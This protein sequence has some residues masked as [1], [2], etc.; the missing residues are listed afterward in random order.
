MD[1]DVPNGFVV[2][3]PVPNGFVPKPEP[4]GFVPP[5]PPNPPVQ[6]QLVAMLHTVPDVHW[7]V[8]IAQ[9]E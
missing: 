3:N 2:P 4:N 8:P 6:Q 5:N 7:F 1:D 9:N